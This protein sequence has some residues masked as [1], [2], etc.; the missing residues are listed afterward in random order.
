MP[1]QNPTR[2][3][4]KLGVKGGA[5]GKKAKMIQLMMRKGLLKASLASRC[6]LKHIHRGMEETEVEVLDD[7]RGIVMEEE[8]ARVIETGVALG[9]DFGGKEDSIREEL[10]RREVE[11]EERL[12]E[13]KSI[14]AFV[15]CPVLGGCGPLVLLLSWSLLLYLSWSLVSPVCVVF[16]C[17]CC[18][19]LFL[20]YYGSLFAWL[21]PS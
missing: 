18:L 5:Q 21:L 16:F 17:L 6:Q 12:K 13:T 9:F 14:G 2:H 15:V 11:D 8:I 1:T 7:G 10:R 4:R 20:L 3:G 19:F